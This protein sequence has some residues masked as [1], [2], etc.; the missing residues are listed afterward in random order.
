V[1]V[2][3]KASIVEAISMSLVERDKEALSL[4]PYKGI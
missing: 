2:K 1:D 4:D 3:V